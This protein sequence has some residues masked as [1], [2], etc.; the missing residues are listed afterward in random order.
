MMNYPKISIVTPVFNQAKFIET[1]IRSVLSQGYPNLEYIII[2][3]GSTDGTVEIIRKYEKELHLFISEPDN[4]MYHALDKGL[5]LTSGEIMAWINADD[6]YHPK[7]LFIVADIFN[8]F[9]DVE[10]L[11]GQ[12]TTLDEEGRFIRVGPVM[13]WGRYDY[14]AEKNTW[15]IQQEST[16][17][18]RPVWERAGGYI[19]TT[20]R[21]ASDSE[22]WSRFI[23]KADAKLFMAN[24]LLGGFR[25]RKDQLSSDKTAYN[26]ELETIFRNIDVAESDL[27]RLKEIEFHKSVLTRLPFLRTIFGW[28]IN[29]R[30]LYDNPPL[31]T[32]DLK[33]GNF[34]KD[35]SA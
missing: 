35:R 18:K 29:L 1:T 5:K 27:K 12:P 28:N 10:F 15:V 30:K 9:A 16:F 22:L 2:D 34:K 32:Y 19:N 26:K 7:S 11:M 25:I 31:I 33:K 8:Q 3:G 24:V 6:I 13:P 23:M 21:L 4:G 14:L 17:W 20:Y